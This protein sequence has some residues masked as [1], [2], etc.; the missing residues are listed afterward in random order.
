MLTSVDGEQVV[1]Q[2]VVWQGIA[3]ERNVSIISPL[4]RS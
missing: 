2:A 4:K 3:E 1:V